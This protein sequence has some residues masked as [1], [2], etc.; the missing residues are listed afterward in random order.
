VQLILRAHEPFPALAVDR[1]WNLVLANRAVMPLLTGVA[2]HLLQPPVNVLRLSLH[3]EGVAPRIENLPEWRAHLLSRLRREAAMAASAELQALLEELSAY[4][5]GES[6]HEPPRDAIVV[7]LRLRTPAGV[8]S[9]FSTTTVFG[10]P[11]EITLDELAL[12][13]FFPADEA[14]AMALRT[15]CL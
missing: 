3:P 10:T 8:L 11:L 4:P 9:F 14:T 13:A 7:P 15:A 1:S 2:P 6:H 12:K 5:G